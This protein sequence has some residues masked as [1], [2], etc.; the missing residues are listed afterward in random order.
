MRAENKQNPAVLVLLL[1]SSLASA[2]S[3]ATLDLCTSRAITPD[4]LTSLSRVLSRFELRAS[5][6]P[7]SGAFVARFVARGEKTMLVVQ[8]PDG[9]A[10]VERVVPWLEKGDDPLTQLIE[11]R[12]V[13]ELSVVLEGL[14]TELSLELGS[15]TGGDDT[16]PVQGVPEGP[17]DAQGSGSS[18][19][20][21]SAAPPAGPNRAG[22]A[23]RANPTHA[24][25]A[26]RANGG[27]GSATGDAAS[28]GQG[29]SQPFNVPA[30][31]ATST[32]AAPNTAASLDAGP[33]SLMSTLEAHA[34]VGL[35]PRYKTPGV[36]TYDVTASG[37]LG[38]VRLGFSWAPQARWSFAGRPI[39]LDSL[40][41]SLAFRPTFWRSGG[42]SFD[43]SLGA[44]TE[45]LALRRLDIDPRALHTWWDVGGRAGAH[46]TRAF[47]VFTVTLQTE[48]TW[49]PA[50]RDISIPDGPTRRLNAFAIAGALLVGARW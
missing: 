46:L 48:G 37:G 41:I 14:V 23:K 28:F 35:S 39:S 47:N 31:S 30:G 7:S 19:A 49:S 32:P 27:R 40:A 42:W 11:K 22:G 16:A 29:S 6:T 1:V 15:K 17:A 45:R 4:E 3:R 8:A 10:S 50:S 43:L 12:K 2:Q 18:S 21:G 33:Q 44:V 36:W 24:S 25:R 34:Q 5:C 20:P 26:P 38:P 13:S 9:G